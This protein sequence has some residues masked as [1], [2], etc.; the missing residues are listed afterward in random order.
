MASLANAFS[1]QSSLSLQ[2]ITSNIEPPQI[3]ITKLDGTIVVRWPL[4]ET[5]FVLEQSGS[6]GPSRLT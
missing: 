2:S 4:T 3:G 6:L 5:G 1:F